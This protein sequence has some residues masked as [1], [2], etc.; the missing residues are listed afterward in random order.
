MERAV[1][2]TAEVT[3]RPRTG[4]PALEITPWRVSPSASAAPGTF[5]IFAA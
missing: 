2:V 4:A 3:P 5:P 1:H